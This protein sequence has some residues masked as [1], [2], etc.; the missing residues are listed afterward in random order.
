M[1]IAAPKKKQDLGDSLIPLA[2]TVVGGM[3]GGPA[4][5]SIGGT[6]GSAVA[7]DDS[8]DQAM[9]SNGADIMSAMRRRKGKAGEQAPEKDVA[10]AYKAAD[11]MGPEG[12]KYKPTL[13]Q[14]LAKAEREKAT[15]QTSMYEY[16]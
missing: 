15:Q 4:G 16:E 1:P 6:L 12:D 5:A 2:G 10:D 14:A 9:L 8:S 3:I 13:A 11:A 7:A